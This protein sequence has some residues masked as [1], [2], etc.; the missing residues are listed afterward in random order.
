MLLPLPLIAWFAFRA[1]FSFAPRRLIFILPVFLLVVA[2]GVTALGRL[3]AWVVRRL[4]PGRPRLTRWASWA[5]I[6]LVMLA[7]VKGSTD[8]I[9]SYYGRPKQDWKGLATILRTVP[10]P[11]DAVVV[12]PNTSWPL[13]WYYPGPHNIIAEDLVPKLQT[14][15]E[16]SPAVYV[17]AVGTGDQLSASD[18]DWLIQNYIRVPFEG[19][20]PLLPKLPPRRVVWR[21]RRAALQA[22]APPSIFLRPAR[23]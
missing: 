6:G 22:G 1:G 14:L 21:G 10:Q 23:H 5:T 11:E 4:A 19:F 2:T 20:A 9:I 15:C 8:P 3:A 16:K 18:A 13:E 17:A 7:F 12:L